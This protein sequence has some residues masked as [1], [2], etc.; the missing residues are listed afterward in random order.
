M[1]GCVS[2]RITGDQAD[3]DKP[4]DYS[5]TMYYALC[6]FPDIMTC[7]LLEEQ[8]AATLTGL[9][10]IKCESGV[11]VWSCSMEGDSSGEEDSSSMSTTA[12]IALLIA[13]VLYLTM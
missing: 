7:E 4:F 11:D 13:A 9:E 12:S 1:T 2:L 8:Q 5:M 3:P 10:N 6:G